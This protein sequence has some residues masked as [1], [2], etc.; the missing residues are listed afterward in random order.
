MDI[1]TQDLGYIYGIIVSTEEETAWKA[2]YI[3]I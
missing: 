3:Q 1:Y 2:D